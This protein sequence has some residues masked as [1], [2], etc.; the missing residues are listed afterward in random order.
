MNRNELNARTIRALFGKSSNCANREPDAA[1]AVVTVEIVRFEVQA[2]RAARI[3]RM[4]RR[5]PVEAARAGIAEGS[6]VAVAGGRRWQGLAGHG[7]PLP[8][9]P[10]RRR[11]YSFARLLS[12]I[13]TGWLIDCSKNEHCKTAR[14]GEIQSASRHSRRN[15]QAR[16][17]ERPVGSS[18]GL[19][20]TLS[21]ATTFSFSQMSRMSETSCG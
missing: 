14:G 18:P 9:R 4:R 16:A 2:P 3:A 10:P 6:P 5:G 17:V 7:R 1:V 15:L 13:P 12:P 8:R 11:R 21:I 19:S 20:S